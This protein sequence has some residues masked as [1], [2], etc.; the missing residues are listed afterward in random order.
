MTNGP[1][2]RRVLGGDRPG[3]QP[4]LPIGR[5]FENLAGA[6]VQKGWF[7]RNAVLFKGMTPTRK[8]ELSGQVP[9]QPNHLTAH[10]HVG[11]CL[12]HSQK[13]F[14]DGFAAI[15][16]R[17]VWRHMLNLFGGNTYISTAPTNFP[18]EHSTLEVA[19]VIPRQCGSRSVDSCDSHYSLILLA[20]LIQSPKGNCSFP[21]VCFCV[22][23]LWVQK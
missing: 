5:C 22:V 16:S 19:K 20:K 14:L 15:R 18:K 2:E 17:C 21:R 11:V 3:R 9:C 12:L 4:I 23:A 1:D 7:L 10:F 6:E 8:D 13:L